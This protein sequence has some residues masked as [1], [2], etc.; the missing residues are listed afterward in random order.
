MEQ[1]KTERL[2]REEKELQEK[3]K[4][5]YNSKRIMGK[6]YQNKTDVFD[7]LSDISQIQTHNENLE[8]IRDRFKESDSNNYRRRERERK[9]ERKIKVNYSFNISSLW[10]FII[11]LFLFLFSLFKYFADSFFF[12]S[13]LFFH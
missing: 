13:F 12:L 8:K 10:G 6:K 2:L 9:R 3:P 7:R 5:N 11:I 1:I 4:I